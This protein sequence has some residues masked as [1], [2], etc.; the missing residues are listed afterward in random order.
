MRKALNFLGLTLAKDNLNS[1][2]FDPCEYKAIEETRIKVHKELLESLEKKEVDRL[3]II[4]TKTSQIITYTGIIFSAL[5]LF[6][7]ILLAKIVEHNLILRVAFIVIMIFAFLFYALAIHN[8]IRN[9]NVGNFPYS[10]SDPRNVIKYQDKSSNEFTSIEIQDL[11]YSYNLNSKSN[12][13]KA[14]N[15][16]Y[17]YR[18]FRIANILTAIMGILI[19]SALLFTKSDVKEG[20]IRNSVKIENLD[21]SIREIINALKL[22]KQQYAIDTTK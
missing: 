15:L 1:D 19:C 9:Y 4:D 8:A 12:D 14:D 3:T 7:P 17:A 6:I 10:R 5:S 18:T 16:I 13:K 2:S 11:L 21:S 22:Q 20:L